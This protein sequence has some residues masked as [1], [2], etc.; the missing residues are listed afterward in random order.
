MSALP[1]DPDGMN[2]QRAAWAAEALNVFR[3][4]DGTAEDA[5]CD[6]LCDLM[7]WCDRN[8][9]QF[10]EQLQRGMGHYREETAKL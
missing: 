10:G 1:P 4:E 2:Q 8:G 6:L 7:H 3:D 9:V 5:L